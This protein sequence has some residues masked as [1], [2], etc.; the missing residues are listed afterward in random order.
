MAGII[1]EN[2]DIQI[3]DKQITVGENIASLVL[4]QLSVKK[5][6]WIGDTLN[7]GVAELGS[8]I[9]RYKLGTTTSNINDMFLAIQN[10]LISLEQDNVIN[11]FSINAP[12]ISKTVATFNIVINK[13]IPVSFSFQ[14]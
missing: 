9:Y 7:S 3:K 13:N 6:T 11:A 4:M 1:I 12:V 10:A 14:L 5:G 8:E 2:N